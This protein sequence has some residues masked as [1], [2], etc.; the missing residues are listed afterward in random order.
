MNKMKRIL[1]L[2]SSENTSYKLLIAELLT[3]SHLEFK[4]NLFSDLEFQ[5]IPH[6]QTGAGFTPAGCEIYAGAKPVSDFDLVYVINAGD[7]NKEKFNILMSYLVKRQIKFVDPILAGGNFYDMRKLSQ[8]SKRISAGLPC[9]KTFVGNNLQECL[10]FFRLHSRDSLDSPRCGD[11]RDD[12]AFRGLV[13]KNSSLDHGEG[14]F[15]ITNLPELEDSLKKGYL[16]QEYF[17]KKI[18]LRVIVIGNEALGCVRRT[19][20]RGEFRSNV[21]HDAIAEVYSLLPE[22]ADLAVK[23]TTAAGFDIAGVD[24]L[25]DQNGQ[26][27]I[28]EVNRSPQ[29]A[30]DIDPL[31]RNFMQVTGINVTAKIADFL[32]KKLAAKGETFG[33]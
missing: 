20:I 26:K 29:Y 30:Y 19:P 25:I 22:L 33:S 21:G 16:I 17:A 5:F 18:D 13:A 27:Y 28:L 31:F 14:V 6:Q 8:I 32:E 3:R 10:K 4:S 15:L 24:I 9:P 12:L 2:A 11:I 1:L 7:A 23:A